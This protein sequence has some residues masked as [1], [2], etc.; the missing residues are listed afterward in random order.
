MRNRNEIE[1][2]HLSLVNG[3]RQQMVRQID[4]YGLYDIWFDYGRYLKEIY[5]GLDVWFEYYTDAV[6]SYHRIKNR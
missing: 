4:A 2:I 6:Q 3:Q 1:Q 5:E